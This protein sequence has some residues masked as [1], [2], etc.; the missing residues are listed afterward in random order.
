MET[1]N[2]IELSAVRAIL[3]RGVRYDL[4]ERT[5]TISPLKLGTVLVICEQLCSA[6]LTVGEIDKGE[7]DLPGF[8]LRYAEVMMRCVAIAELNSKEAV[9]GEKITEIAS[10]YRDNLTA[11]QIHEL[12]VFVVSLSGMQ[13]FTSTIRLML[14]IRTVNLSPKTNRGS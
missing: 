8:F 12:F 14:T 3:D 13:D 4:G 6:G 2:D 5:L 11:H 9:N 10:W 7:E 1:N